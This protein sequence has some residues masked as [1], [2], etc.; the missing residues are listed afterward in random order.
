[1]K[2]TALS[3]C[4]IILGIFTAGAEAQIPAPSA[5]VR[6]FYAH[7]RNANAAFNQRNLETRKKYLTPRLYNLFREELRKERA[8]LRSNPDDKPFF[9]DGFPFR[10]IDEDCQA[11]GRILKRRYQVGNAARTRASRTDVA[12]TVRLCVADRRHHF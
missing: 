9:G 11:N 10:P 2:L 1:M 7:D 12:S 3:F 6:A 5:A 8:H 4:L